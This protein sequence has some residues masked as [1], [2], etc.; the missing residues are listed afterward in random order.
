[1]RRRDVWQRD[2]SD[3]D[4]GGSAEASGDVVRRSARRRVEPGAEHN[5]E[6][7]AKPAADNDE[8][9]DIDDA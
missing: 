7:A 1:V 9:E 3:I 8:F 2:D 5:A 6:P 4:G